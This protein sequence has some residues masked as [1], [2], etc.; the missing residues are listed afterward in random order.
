MT[1][2]VAESGGEREREEKVERERQV[3]ISEKPRNFFSE[4]FFLRKYLY[5]LKV[6]YTEFLL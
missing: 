5:F 3:L 1:E 4:Y 6:V 2:A